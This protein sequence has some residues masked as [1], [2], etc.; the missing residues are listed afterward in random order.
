MRTPRLLLPKSEHFVGRS[1]KQCCG[2]SLTCAAGR[3]RDA[4]A[5][6]QPKS[7]TT[8]PSVGSRWTG[9][10]AGRNTQLLLKA[11]VVERTEGWILTH[12][13]VRSRADVATRLLNGR[14]RGGRITVTRRRAFF[15]LA[16]PVVRSRTSA[17]SPPMS[18]SQAMSRTTTEKSTTRVPGGLRLLSIPQWSTASHTAAG[19]VPRNHEAT[20]G[21]QS[22]F[23]GAA[24]FQRPAGPSR[25]CLSAVPSGPEPHSQSC[26]S[27]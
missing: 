27:R 21:I 5:A 4:S 1:K 3:L 23:S 17:A 8:S 12:D 16:P 7:S 14:H 19:S 25:G 11:D 24:A 26:A 10:T 6:D 15:A 9:G 22:R 20:L 18:G 2:S 13:S